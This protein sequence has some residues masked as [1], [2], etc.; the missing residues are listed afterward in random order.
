MLSLRLLYFQF[1]KWVIIVHSM[2]KV[3][4]SNNHSRANIQRILKLYI[5][6]NLQSHSHHYENLWYK[7]AK[8]IYY[9]LKKAGFWRS[10]TAESYLKDVVM[11]WLC[12]N[13]SGSE[14]FAGLDC[15]AEQMACYRRFGAANR[16]NIIC[17]ATSL[18]IGLSRNSLSIPWKGKRYFFI[19]K[20]LY[21]F[22]DPLSLQ[23][24]EYREA[25]SAALEWSGT[26]WTIL[27][28]LTH[29]YEAFT[30]TTVRST[31]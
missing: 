17:V 27:P 21:W 29:D 14:I 28:L 6:Y 20:C 16:F 26:L 4:R 23:F 30:R 3:W 5:E 7:D 24:K 11:S 8:Q 10:T 22:W 9:R 25:T 31:W 15:Y 12:I 19:P 18:R 1:N 13:C 2:Y